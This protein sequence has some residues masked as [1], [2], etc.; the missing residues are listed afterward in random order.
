ML[1]HK[2]QRK[3]FTTAAEPFGTALGLS[4]DSPLIQLALARLCL[5]QARWER[6][7]QLDAGPSIARGQSLVSHLLKTRPRWGEALAIR[8]GLNLVEA[9]GLSPSGRPQKAKEAQQDFA[10]AFSSNRN[11]VV[12]WK[13]LAQQAEAMA[14]P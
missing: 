2:A 1:R 6:T 3:D 10:E 11:L 14:A 12:A 9:E 5:A 7:T 4:S 13:P 8:G